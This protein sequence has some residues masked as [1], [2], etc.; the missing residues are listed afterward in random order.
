MLTCPACKLAAL[1]LLTV[2]GNGTAQH[3][4]ETC[5]K[6]HVIAPLVAKRAALLSQV[7]AADAALTAAL[8]KLTKTYHHAGASIFT[9]EC[10]KRHTSS[11]DLLSHLEDC[12]PAKPVSARKQEL[13]RRIHAVTA[14]EIG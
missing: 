6:R 4:C 9:C 3:Y 11:L 8:E 7:A 5:Y 2:G 13:D 14:D 12:R 10:G 1:E